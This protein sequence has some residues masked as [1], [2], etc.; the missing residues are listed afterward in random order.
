L[1][2]KFSR[3]RWG[4]FAPNTKCAGKFLRRKGK[5]CLSRNSCWWLKNTWIVSVYEE[6][7]VLQNSG[8]YKN[9]N[10]QGAG[11]EYAG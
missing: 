7:M 9:D 10:A 6:I 2:L 11:G 3:S 4:D 8:K 5:P 1:I